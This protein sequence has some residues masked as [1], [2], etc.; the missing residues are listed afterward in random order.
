MYTLEI[1]HAVAPT[2][3]PGSNLTI[4]Q[5]KA[6]RM[7]YLNALNEAYEYFKKSM[8]KTNRTIV[9]KNIFFTYKNVINLGFS[10]PWI[11][12]LQFPSR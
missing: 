7:A 4:A 10:I 2:L 5:E 8:D 11:W 12:H 6:L 1:I 3:L 9:S